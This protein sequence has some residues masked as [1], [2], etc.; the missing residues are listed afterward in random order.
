MWQRA[1]IFSDPQTGWEW[2]Q[3]TMLGLSHLVRVLIT[4]HRAG[5][6]DVIL[7]LGS[8]ELEPWLTTVQQR[9]SDIPELFWAGRDGWPDLM[10]DAPVLG[11]RG[12]VLFTPSL[13]DWLR[14]MVGDACA[15]DAGADDHHIS[16]FG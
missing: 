1:V 13:L 7:P 4:L 6:R 15:G 12:G 5:V 3:H 11:V 9:R 2:S 16:G 14:Q 8:E 10:A